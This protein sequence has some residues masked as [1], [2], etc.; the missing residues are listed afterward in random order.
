[1]SM[2]FG[3]APIIFPAILGKPMAFRPAFYAHLVLLHLT[4]ALRVFGDLTDWMPGREWGGLLN[5]IVILMFMG[6]S[7]SALHAKDRPTE[8][9]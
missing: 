1:M 5:A 9:H 2:I 7:M 3:H 8:S 6:N 4:L